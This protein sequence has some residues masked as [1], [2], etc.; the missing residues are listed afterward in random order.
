MRRKKQVE[1][2]TECKGNVNKSSQS[3]RYLR[4]PEGPTTSSKKPEVMRT[5]GL[6]ATEL[7][8][9]RDSRIQGGQAKIT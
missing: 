3:S 4:N 7:K 8:R 2:V 1:A 6:G 5:A 9:N